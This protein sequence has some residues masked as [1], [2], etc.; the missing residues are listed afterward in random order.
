MARRV[1]K[2]SDRVVLQEGESQRKNG[3]YSFRWTDISGVRHSIYAKTLAQL[4]EKEKEVDMDI[5]DGIR[6]EM[7]NRPVNDF[8]DLWSGIKRGVK[9]NTM[10]NYRYMYTSLYAHPLAG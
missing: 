2:D 4:R 8:F 7:R 1:R 5:H 10:Q 9:E 3:T 6:P